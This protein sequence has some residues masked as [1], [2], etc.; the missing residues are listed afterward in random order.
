MNVSGALSAARI[1]AYP[2]ARLRLVCKPLAM[3][4]APTIE[5]VQSL[6]MA[7]RETMYDAQGYGLSAVQI[8]VHARLFIVHVPGECDFPL[9]FAN[10]VI[11]SASADR[12]T[13]S[14][15]CLSF[16]GIREP[17][18]RPKRVTIRRYD[19]H[20]GLDEREFE[21]WTARAI[22]HECEHLDGKLLIDHMLPS[23]RRMLDRGLKRRAAKHP[24][25]V[26]A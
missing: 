20:G 12:C 15:G 22:Q 4:D 8:G 16:S 17:I 2:D 24:E 11:V 18:D 21:G 6:V 1:I 9:V 3:H 26:P 23:A 7:M 5:Q 19:E 25:R 10:P 13:M 14:E